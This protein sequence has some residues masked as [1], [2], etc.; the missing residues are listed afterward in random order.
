MSR[1]LSDIQ[2]N[3]CGTSRYYLVYKKPRKDKKEA[4]PQEGYAISESNLEKPNKI[5]RCMACGLVYAIRDISTRH[6]AKDYESMV[7]ADYI[8]EENGRRAQARIILSK[9]KFKRGGRL[10][11]IGCGPGFFLDEAK[12]CGWSAEGLDLSLWAK[13]YCKEHFNIDVFQG[14]LEEVKFPDRSFD[15]IVMMDVI[16]HLE[17]PKSTLKELRRILKNDGIIYISTPDINSLWSKLLGARWWGVN[18]YHLFYFSRKT[19]EQIFEAVGFKRS[20]YSSYPRIFSLNYW[21]K[22]LESYPYLIG[23]PIHFISKIGN[24][25]EWL[26]QVVLYD[27]IGV[28]AR[29]IQRLDTVITYD[30]T[31]KHPSKERKKVIVVLPAYNAEKTLEQTVADIPTDAADEIILVD[32]ASKDNTVKLAKKIGLA[33]YQHKQNLGYGANQKTC[34]QKAIEHGADIVVMVHP[35]YQYDPKIIPQLIEPIKEGR[36]DAVFGSRMMKGGALEGGMPL[37]KHN[38]NILLTAF[39]NVM[40]STY[41]TEYHSGF[42]AY[43]TRMLRQIHF[44]ANSNGFIFDTEIIV[45]VVANHF[46]IEEIPIRTRYFEEASSIKLW[47]SILYGLGIIRVILSYFL[48]SHGW[49]KN[50]KLEMVQEHGT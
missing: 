24:L 36:A 30:D 4:S 11:D 32:D 23:A 44:K 9:F 2:C 33:V 5:V 27:Q 28:I 15:V 26:L 21:A 25:G 13:K 6:I 10:L 3:Y 34:Y 45:Q 41:L 14:T 31:E 50:E 1:K 12:R 46:K 18:K 40:L 49:I 35:D 22:R 39:E 37:W 38:A 8:K 7:D 16:E 42:R 43:S 48:H 17:D 29:K 20:R 19:L 47:P